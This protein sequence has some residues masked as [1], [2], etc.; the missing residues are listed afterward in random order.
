MK[1]APAGTQSCVDVPLWSYFGQNVPDHFRIKI[2]RIT[3]LTYFGTTMSDKH[4]ELGNR[5]KTPEK[6]ILWIII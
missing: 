5:E 4:L 1:G 6:P 3:Y 2:V